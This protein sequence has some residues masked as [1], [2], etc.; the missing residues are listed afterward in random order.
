MRILLNKKFVMFGMINGTINQLYAV[1]W[2]IINIKYHIYSTKIFGNN[3]NIISN[4]LQH[5]FHTDKTY[6][7]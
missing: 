1:D 7:L 4:T 5:Y 2:L 3:H 6:L